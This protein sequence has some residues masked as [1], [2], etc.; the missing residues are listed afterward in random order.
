MKKSLILSLCTI[1]IS[2][3]CTQTSAKQFEFDGRTFDLPM[4]ADLAK[5]TFD[6]DKFDRNG[7]INNRKI[8]AHK[9]NDEIIIGITSYIRDYKE[10]SAQS[11][12]VREYLR[13]KYIADLEE[14]YKSVFKLLDISNTAF[15]NP[16]FMF[17]ELKDGSI[18]VVGTMYYNLMYNTYTTV[19]FFRGITLDELPHYLSVLY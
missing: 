3:S 19:S 16:D 5:K 12:D 15:I 14:E 6:L 8:L 10:N 17:M 9:K 1:W 11:V 2:I 18:I 7:G 4:T 13:K